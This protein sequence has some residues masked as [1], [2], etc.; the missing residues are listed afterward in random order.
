MPRRKAPSLDLSDAELENIYWTYR[1]DKWAEDMIE[2]ILDIKLD[3]WQKQFLVDT[4]K[5]QL[6]LV[7][8]QAGKSTSVAI[9]A[10]H[11]AIFRS[12]QTILLVSPTQ[13]QSSELFHTVR[14]L[15][16]SI[17]EYAYDLVVDNVTS[18]E[19][20]N[21]SRIYS[22]PGTQWNIRGY[23]ANLI[24]IDEAAGVPDEVFSAVSPMLLTTQG[25]FVL[26]STPQRK[27]GEFYKAFVSDVW[28]KYVIPASQNP[29]MQTQEMQ[30]FLHTEL[31]THGSRIYS[32]EYECEFLDDMD[33]GRVKRGWWQFY[34]IGDIQA[35]RSRSQ[36][37]YI[38]WDTAQKVKE[39]SDYSVATVWLRVRDY[40]YLLEMIC[41][42]MLFPDL[43][44]TAIALNDRYRP[45]YN[46]IE[47][48]S[49]GTSLIQVL[50][51]K[52]PNMPIKPMDPGDMDKGQRLDL[53][54]PA[55]ENGCVFLPATMMEGGVLVPTSTAGDVM[56]NLAQFPDGE[57]D[58]ITDSVSQFLTYIRGHDEP[59]SIEFF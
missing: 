55:I 46:L 57:H 37:I 9:K 5:R 13:R 59:I 51:E 30:D 23:S 12:D 8:R 2:P 7:H 50:R 29:R 20:R 47:D 44:R 22:L 1:P 38:S 14:K 53:A 24:I 40:Y 6:L 21:G 28:Q 16:K 32:Q 48:K 58:D 45:T 4:R 17:P 15:V 43:V 34:D 41:E 39:L 19:L 18:L 25:Q 52:R 56:D 36:D 42:K 10:L 11:R 26:V 35:L 3:P 27:Q 33:S 49:S 31:I 54:T